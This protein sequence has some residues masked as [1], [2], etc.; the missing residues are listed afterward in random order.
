MLFKEINKYYAAGKQIVV[1]DTQ[2]AEAARWLSESG[3]DTAALTRRENY[4]PAGSGLTWDL[5]GL[6][7]TV[8]L[9]ECFRYPMFL[10]PG[11]RFGDILMVGMRRFVTAG[12][13]RREQSAYANGR[14]SMHQPAPRIR[15]PGGPDGRA[16][17]PK[18]TRAGL[19]GRVLP[20]DR[21][22][23][24]RGVRD[25]KARAP[26]VGRG[27]LAED[28]VVA[29]AIRTLRRARGRKESWP[30]CPTTSPDTD[31]RRGRRSP[32]APALAA[33]AGVGPMRRVRRGGRDEARPVG[34]SA[35]LDTQSHPRREGDPLDPSRAAAAPSGA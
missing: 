31:V 3:E 9:C 22:R 21:E 24:D 1:D 4:P 32:V 14:C 17:R 6:F 34:V 12:A 28:C 16:L 29:E 11:E 10:F 35:S 30:R 13:V 7:C 27:D 23:P 8:C 15:R 2:A 5:L 26:A 19:S 18:E 33:A 20:V 25:A